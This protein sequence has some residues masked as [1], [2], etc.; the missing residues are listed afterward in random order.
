MFFFKLYFYIYLF[1][2]VVFFS[3]GRGKGFHVVIIIIPVLSWPS[4]QGVICYD[5]DPSSVRV[6]VRVCIGGLNFWP[7]PY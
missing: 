6:R 1:F 2:C 7:Q 3:V 4:F 5:D